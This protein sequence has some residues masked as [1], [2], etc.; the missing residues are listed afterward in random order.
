MKLKPMDNKGQLGLDNLAGAAVL[1][2]VS[3]ITVGLGATILSSIQATQTA[4]SVA[5]N[6]SQGGLLSFQNMANLMPILG[7]V[8]IA[9]VVL[10]VLALA[11]RSR[12]A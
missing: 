3:V 1:L 11:F 2:V 9:A 6:S 12:S 5:W 10:G 4:S 7:L 8:I